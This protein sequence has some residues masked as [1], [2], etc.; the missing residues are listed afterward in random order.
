MCV[1]LGESSQSASHPN[2]W[3]LGLTVCLLLVLVVVMLLL[4]HHPDRP[5][6]LSSYYLAFNGRLGRLAMDYE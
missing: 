2:M 3:S 1:M 5:T 6:D 4:L